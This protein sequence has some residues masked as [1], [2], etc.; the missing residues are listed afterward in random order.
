MGVQDRPENGGIAV[1]GM[2]CRF[3]GA[4]DLQGYWEMIAK[5]DDGF[6]PVPADRWDF[7]AFFDAN[8]RAVDKSYAPAGGVLDDVRS[9]PAIALQIPPAPRRGH[10]PTAAPWA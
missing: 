3:A 7:D 4:Q 5:G 9:F 10:G 2:G 1:V 6:G 8:P